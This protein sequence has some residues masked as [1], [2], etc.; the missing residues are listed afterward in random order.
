MKHK[1]VYVVTEI[2]TNSEANVDINV[3]NSIDSAHKDYK[4]RYDFYIRRY[5]YRHIYTRQII[6][7]NQYDISSTIILYNGSKITIRLVK[8]PIK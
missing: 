1:Y 6:R 7:D 4:D 8:T 2:T 5:G 3:Y